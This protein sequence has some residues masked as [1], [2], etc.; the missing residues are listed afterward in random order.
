LR[1][2]AGKSLLLRAFPHDN[3]YAGGAVSGPWSFKYEAAQ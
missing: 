1:P 3:G 2:T